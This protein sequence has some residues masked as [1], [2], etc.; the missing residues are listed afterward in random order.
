[1]GLLVGSIA[2]LSSAELTLP[3]FGFLF[4]FAGGSV[5]A[6]M[7]KIPKPTLSLAGIALASFS[8]AAVIA[9]YAGLYI[10]VNE[11]LFSSPEKITVENNRSSTKP[12]E[13][14]G[15]EVAQ[16][17]FR[18]LLRS[19]P[20]EKFE[21]YLREEMDLGHKTLADACKELSEWNPSDE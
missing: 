19:N 2:G 15:N 1:M 5:M 11:V 21:D 10:K 3:L 14:P 20:R 18:D 13:P 8:L 6:F 4:A 7:G 16:S 9:L 12:S 17:N